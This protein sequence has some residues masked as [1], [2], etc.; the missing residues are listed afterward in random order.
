MGDIPDSS[1][2]A[3]FVAKLRALAITIEQTEVPDEMNI[4]PYRFSKDFSLLLER[5][6]KCVSNG[7]LLAHLEAEK[8]I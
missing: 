6:W 2:D 4:G 5:L 1:Q 8:G 3:I 7:V